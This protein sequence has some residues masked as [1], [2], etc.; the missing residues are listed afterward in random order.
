MAGR[1]RYQFETFAGKLRKV[2][3]ELGYGLNVD[4][5]G[6]Y[7]ASEGLLFLGYGITD[8]VAFELEAAVITARQD[9]AADDPSNMPAR[10]EESG[11]GDVESQLRVLLAQETEDRPGVFSYFETVFPLQRTRRLIGTKDWEFVLGGGIVRGFAWGTITVRLAT[12]YDREENTM[13]FGEYALEYL[14][15][16]SPR[17]R[18]FA[19]VE[20]SEDEVEL[21]TEAQVFL[22]PNI[23]LKLNNAFGATSKATGWAPE[24]GVMFSFQ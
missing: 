9:K 14:K 16:V 21:I 13:A 19:A 1:N 3:K 20:G 4:F 23:F 12:E 10:V 15:R 17:L 11:L 24:V 18:L 22:R 7:R 6:E 2:R 8:R 5:R